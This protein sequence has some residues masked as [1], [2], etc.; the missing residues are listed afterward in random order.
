MEVKKLKRIGIVVLVLAVALFIFQNT[1]AAPIS[2]FLWD[3]NAP[4]ILVMLLPLLIGI[5]VGVYIARNVGKE[6]PEAKPT[7]DEPP[8]E[9]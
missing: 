2:L 4:L 6:K 5:A 7:P 8:T 9:Q 3:V 1:D